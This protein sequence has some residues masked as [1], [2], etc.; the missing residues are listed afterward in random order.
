[1]GRF[2]INGGRKLSG[3]ISVSGSKNAALPLIFA[4]ITAHGISTFANIP[5][6]I[7]VEIAFEI[8][9]NMGAE[10]TRAGELATV[11]T[12][13]LEYSPPSE[14]SVSKIRASSYLIGACLARFGK[15][16]ILRFGGCNFDN[17]PIDMHISAAIALGARLSGDLLF[18]DKLIG[19]DIHFDKISVGAT[20]NAIIM[21]ASAIGKSRIYG[22]ARE[23][24]VISL[25]EYLR[26]AGAKISLCDEYIEIF[27]ADLKEGSA[28]IIP[29]MIE[30]GSY[31]SLSLMNNSELC[32]RG[33]DF[34]HLE[35]FLVE[36]VKSGAVVEYNAESVTVSGSLTE[37]MNIITAPYPEFPTDLQPLTAPLLAR[38]Y[39]GKITEG[40]WHNRFGY[41]GELS[42]FGVEYESFDGYSVVKPSRLKSANATS[43]DLR[44]GMALVLAA[45]S[46]NGE[47]VIYGSELIKRGYADIV[48]KLRKIGAEIYEE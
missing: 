11:N 16:E 15:V 9:R 18:A 36:V 40:V 10:V 32:V 35:S 2:I 25:V 20:V 6:I 31:L 8:L 17:R 4:S 38:F 39:G 14:A 3:E 41:L 29:D 28:R 43:P 26:S 13:N 30:A 5:D 24:H 47:S 7:D 33:A 21:A 1:M 48:G 37:P 27:G 44:G 23:P 42:K 45:L 34:G 19:A 46:T 12:S 22:Y